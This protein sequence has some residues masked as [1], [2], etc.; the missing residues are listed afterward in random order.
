MLVQKH[1]GR[2]MQHNRN[3]RRQPTQVQSANPQNNGN[4]SGKKVD[5]FNRCCGNWVTACRRNRIPSFH[6]IQM[7]I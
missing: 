5:Y 3:P 6:H 4:I 2:S 7:Q 1:R